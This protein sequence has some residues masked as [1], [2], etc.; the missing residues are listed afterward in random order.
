MVYISYYLTSNSI[1]HPDL[2]I[3]LP[4]Q[5]LKEMAYEISPALAM[6][7]QASLNQGTLPNIWKMAKV[8]RRVTDQIRAITDLC[9][10]H[11]FFVKY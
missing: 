5:F 8:V 10:L 7:F 11:V 1:R 2:T 9:L 3:N 4:S 6:I